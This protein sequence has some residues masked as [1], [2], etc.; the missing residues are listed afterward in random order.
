M[1]GNRLRRSIL[2]H[3][4]K[5]CSVIVSEDIAGLGNHPYLQKGGV[6]RRLHD[7]LCYASIIVTPSPEHALFHTWLFAESQPLVGRMTAENDHLLSACEY[8]HSRS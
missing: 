4:L 6:L 5:R 2:I 3:S 8:R 1:I 7:S